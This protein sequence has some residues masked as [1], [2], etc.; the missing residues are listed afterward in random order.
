[1]RTNPIKPIKSLMRIRIPNRYRRCYELAYKATYEESA[2]EKFKLVHGQTG[3]GPD[4]RFAF[5]GH[6][7]IELDDGT[8]YDVVDDRTYTMGEYIERYSIVEIDDRYT[9]RQAI[10][11]GARTGYWGPWRGLFSGHLGP[12]RP[13]LDSKGMIVRPMPPCP[14]WR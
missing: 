3:F 4:D 1:M 7:W 8:I 11:L 13:P 9:R 6:A 12:P 10:R 14:P 2:A 5:R